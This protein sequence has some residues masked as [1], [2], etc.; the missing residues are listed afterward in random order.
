M[1]WDELY[2]LF[3][4]T[5][6]CDAYKTELEFCRSIKDI[7]SVFIPGGKN[8]KNKKIKLTNLKK[9]FENTKEKV[10]S[11][12]LVMDEIKVKQTGTAYLL[13]TLGRVILPD[14]TGNK[15]NANYLQLVKNIATVN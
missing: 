13:Y 7:D 8:K 6:G 1:S 14:L 15:V 4:G 12:V 5:L 2:K 10:K 11:G 3:E 9:E